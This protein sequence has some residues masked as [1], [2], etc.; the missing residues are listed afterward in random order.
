MQYVPFT[1]K[2]GATITSKAMLPISI[3][4]RRNESIYIATK[5]ILGSVFTLAGT[6]DVDVT[7]VFVVWRN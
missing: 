3:S 5:I 4:Y 7:T 6:L 2:L 1:K